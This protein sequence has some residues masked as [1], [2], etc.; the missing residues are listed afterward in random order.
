MTIAV[1]F[2]LLKLAGENG[3]AAF[4]IILYIDTF[5]I[6]FSMSLCE[7]MQPALSYNYAKKDSVRLKSLVVYIFST[8]FLL[9]LGVFVV[10][11]L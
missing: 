4:S 2:L 10:I 5:I 11:M 1:N 3:V 8:A 7:G 6:Y 9:C